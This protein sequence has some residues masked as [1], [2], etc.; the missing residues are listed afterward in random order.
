M[1]EAVEYVFNVFVLIPH[2]VSLTA[3]DTGCG[4]GYVYISN[5]ISG[6]GDLAPNDFDWR[7][8]VARVVVNHK[9]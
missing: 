9:K 1:V 8:P 7:N 4:E 5:G 2:P 6:I 3:T